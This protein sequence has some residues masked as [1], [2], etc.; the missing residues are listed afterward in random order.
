M[1]ARSVHGNE[2]VTHA[3]DSMCGMQPVVDARRKRTALS[4]VWEP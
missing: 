3:F 2:K 4:A 1:L